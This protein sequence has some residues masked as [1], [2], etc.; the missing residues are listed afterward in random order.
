MAAHGPLCRGRPTT[1]RTHPQPEVAM[2][3]RPTTDAELQAALAPASQEDDLTTFN[4]A[5]SLRTA[6]AH[7]ITPAQ[8]MR[9][10]RVQSAYVAASHVSAPI[11]GGIYFDVHY[12]D[13]HGV[14]SSY[15][16]AVEP[17]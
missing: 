8:A 17:I 3:D 1:P 14:T 6:V 5:N 9:E 12:T 7:E 16:V 15:R 10:Q 13:P 11:G 4:L 2:I